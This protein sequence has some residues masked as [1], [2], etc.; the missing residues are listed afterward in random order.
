MNEKQCSFCMLHETLGPWKLQGAP[1][2]RDVGVL[3][4]LGKIITVE[5]HSKLLVTTTDQVQPQMRQLPADH[6]LMME[7]GSTILEFEY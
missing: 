5:L 3:H 1:A 6:V 7:G 2:T 4:S